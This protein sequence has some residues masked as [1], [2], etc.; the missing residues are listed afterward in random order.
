MKH[1]IW[2]LLPVVVLGCA[3]P[4]ST[5]SAPS[6]PA[7][8]STTSGTPAPTGGTVMPGGPGGGI[9]TGD[10]AESVARPAQPAPTTQPATT[11]PAKP[12]IPKSPGR[13]VD[14][15]EALKNP[16]V[17]VASTKIDG[18]DPLTAAMQ[19]YFSV[20]AKAQILNFQNQVKISRELNDGKPLKY[21]Q[22]MELVQMMKIEFMD[23]PPWQMLG[24]DTKAG[25]ITLLEDK[26]VKIAHY[27]QSNIP[28]DAGDEK[29]DTP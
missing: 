18:D 21:E 7:P 28:L 10:L 29:F 16:K 27:K 23:L 8:T 3:K 2:A 20:R 15:T 25:T 17:V 11:E 22:F 4:V 12:A 14:A 1:L 9:V 5:P 13:L 6:T 19:A 24:Y 26:S